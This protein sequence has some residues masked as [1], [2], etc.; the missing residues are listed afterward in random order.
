MHHYTILRILLAGFLLYFAWPYI[1]GAA[2]QIEKIFWGSW[3]GFLLLVIGGN[4]LTLLELSRPPV[5]EQKQEV[6]TKERSHQR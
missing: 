6:I 5:M 1:P 3:L 4:L 2:T